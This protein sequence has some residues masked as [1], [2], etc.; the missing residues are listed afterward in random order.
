MAL[1]GPG[2]SSQHPHG[3]LQTTVTPAPGV[4]EGT[5]HIHNAH[6]YM[7]ASRRAAV[8]VEITLPSVDTKTRIVF[9]KRRRVYAGAILSDLGPETQI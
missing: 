2:F 5:R 7:Q 4:S 1:R 9:L 3:G 8:E 6:T